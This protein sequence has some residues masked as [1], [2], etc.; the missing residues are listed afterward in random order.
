V[1]LLLA[2]TIVPVEEGTWAHHIADR[3]MQCQT[4][5]QL[6]MPLKSIMQLM[7]FFLT[8]HTAAA[9]A[10]CTCLERRFVIELVIKMTT[11]I[12]QNK[13]QKLNL[14]RLALPAETCSGQAYKNQRAIY[15]TLL[16]FAE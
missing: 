3:A 15:A 14:D 11:S 2:R 16:K 13:K 5:L 9:T 4:A 10:E 6:P 8:T 1:Y 7:S 12:S